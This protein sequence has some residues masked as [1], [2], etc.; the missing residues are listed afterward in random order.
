MPPAFLIQPFLDMASS[1]WAMPEEQWVDDAPIKRDMDL[2][3]KE[4][5]GESRIDDK[6]LRQE[7]IQ[8]WKSGKASL[9]IKELPGRTRLIFLGTDEQWDSIPWRTWSRIIQAIGHPIGH[10]LFYGHP[11]ER[12]FPADPAKETVAAIHMNA[13]YSYMCDQSIVVIYRFEEATRVLLHEL[14]HT[15][16]FDKGL[17]V[18]ALEASTEA[19]TELL[20]CAL[21]SKGQPGKFS[22]LWKQQCAWIQAQ[23]NHLVIN[24]GVKGQADYAWR[25][26]IGKHEKLMEMNMFVKANPAPQAGLRFT[27][28]EWDR[29]MM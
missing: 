16:C 22:R 6:N 8:M 5:V 12:Y 23:T 20:L 1:V 27:T 10:V 28:P 11:S 4:A 24:H 15:A 26:T 9:R 17:S 25:Y 18:E 3:Q 14:L 7:M 2:N 29:Y 21:L 13:G 19:W